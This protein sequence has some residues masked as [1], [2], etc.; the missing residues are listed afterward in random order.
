MSSDPDLSDLFDGSPYQVT[1]DG[2][3]AIRS[4]YTD[5]LSLEGKS[6]DEFVSAG[7]KKTTGTPPI[8]KYQGWFRKLYVPSVTGTPSERMLNKAAAFGG[9]AL[10]PTF[11]PNSDLCQSGGNS[12][13]YGLYYETGTA[14]GRTVFKG[15]D[16]TQFVQDIIDLGPGLA[17]SPSIHAAKQQG[18]TGTV[19]SQL[20]T[21]QIVEVEVIPALIV[22]SGIQYW[23]EGRPE[24]SP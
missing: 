23:H 5:A 19:I 7:V 12:R 24:S 3:I 22:K 18:E 9:I 2:T 4:G 17:S 21:G 20:S 8:E 10:F 16:N 15:A 1:A 6:F 14:F 11:I 13:L